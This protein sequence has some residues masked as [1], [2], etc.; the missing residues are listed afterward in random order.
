MAAVDWTSTLAQNK[1]KGILLNEKIFNETFDEVVNKA[2]DHDMG[3][4]YV[5]E[6]LLKPKAR[7]VLQAR[8]PFLDNYLVGNYE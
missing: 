2:F 6:G 3:F 5:S 1:K 7:I 4:G 8:N